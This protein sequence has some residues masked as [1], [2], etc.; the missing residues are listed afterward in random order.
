MAARGRDRHHD[1]SIRNPIRQCVANRRWLQY[2][3]A[4]V[5]G[6]L[7]DVY[8][9]RPQR[10]RS[11]PR[12]EFRGTRQLRGE[13][14]ER[15]VARQQ[16]RAI[17]HWTNPA[18]II[19]GTQLTGTQLSATVSVVGP[20]L[21]GGLIYTPVAGTV[22][23]AEAVSANRRRQRHRQY[24]AATAVVHI[25]VLYNFKGLSGRLRMRTS[26]PARNHRHQVSAEGCQRPFRHRP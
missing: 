25:N 1:V 20:A 22:L 19:Y 23:G 24:N 9:C 15:H 16:S 10:R 17:I 26:F 6:Q 2:S 5:G 18:D 12:R 21:A 7:V 8:G 11:L 14:S 13:Q 4:R 3:D